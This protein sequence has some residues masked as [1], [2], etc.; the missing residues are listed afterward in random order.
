MTFPQEQVTIR[1]V[2]R[3]FSTTVRTWLVW[4]VG[5]VAPAPDA[6][7]GVAVARAGAAP[8]PSRTMRANGPDAL[9]AGADGIGAMIVVSSPLSTGRS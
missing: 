2:I 6:G 1:R 3:P 8:E 9:L 7:P 4:A 5:A